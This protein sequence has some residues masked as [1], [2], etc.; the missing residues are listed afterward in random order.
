MLRG[1]A[2]KLKDLLS[3]LDRDYFYLMHLSY[4]NA[5]SRKP[6][7]EFACDN[8][9]IGLDKYYPVDINRKWQEVPERKKNGLAPLWRQQLELF[10]HEMVEGDCVLI[11]EGMYHF[12]G[13]GLVED[14]Y[15]FKPELSEKFFRHVR[16]V[17]WLLKYE[18]AK[19]TPFKV[20]H[21]TN[22][23]RRVDSHSVYWPIID[24]ELELR[25]ATRKAKE[26]ATKTKEKI[27]PEGGL[28]EIRTEIAIRNP[29]LILEARRRYGTECM[30][31]G[32]D[33]ERKYGELGDG[34]IE[35][36]HLKPLS[37]RRNVAPTRIEDVSVVCSNCHRMIHKKRPPI[38][39]ASL[40]HMIRK[41]M[42]R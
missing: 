32:F 6:L 37:K 15:M 7:W 10:C 16:P 30:V 34:F 26:V 38:S 33:F 29:K 17:H 27:Y 20:G 9:L 12:L 19:R 23:L 24:H 31:C 22:T 21:F 3:E 39:P 35:V 42:A 40:K 25:S 28:R 8:K 13:L 14:P 11:V 18:Y 36:H 1:R 4:G 2:I 5:P 41:E